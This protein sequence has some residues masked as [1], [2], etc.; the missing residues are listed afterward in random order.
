MSRKGEL[1]NRRKPFLLDAS[2]DILGYMQISKGLCMWDCL[3]AVLTV[4][5]TATAMLALPAWA[6]EIDC[7]QCHKELTEG[8]VVHPA[9]LM[10]CGS[11]HTRLDASVVPHKFKGKLGLSAKPPALCFQCHDKGAFTKKFIH[12]PVKAGMCLFCHTPHSGPY[13][14]LLKA[15][16]N[17]PCLQCH[18]ELSY[19]PY[20][21]FPH[22]DHPLSGGPD[23]VRKGK[24]FGCISCHV[25][26]SSDWGKLFRYKATDFEGLC[27]NC[28]HL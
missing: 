24:P 2:S 26:H 23:P 17:A 15:N 6:G 21:P 1:P 13:D 7:L 12:A 16:G 9:V 10:G 8:K 28:H 4:L 22:P 20:L 3:L 19:E 25:P 11:C 5:I 27:K 14:S 18:A